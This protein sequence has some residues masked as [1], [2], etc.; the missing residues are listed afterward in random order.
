MRG[1]AGALPRPQGSRRDVSHARLIAGA[2]VV[3][4]ALLAAAHLLGQAWSGWFAL[5]GRLLDPDGY[6]RLVRVERLVE[7]GRWFDGTIPRSN[8][9][10]GETLHWTRPLDALLIAGAAPL[11]PLLGWRDALFAWGVWLS[12]VL[13]AVSLLALLWAARPLLDARGLLALAALYPMQLFLA[14]QFSLGRPDH[15]GLLLLLFIAQLGFAA[16]GRAIAALPAALAVWVSVEALPAG[17]LP[18]AFAGAL[19]LRS[20]EGARFG[21]AYAALLAA[22]LAAA[23]LAERGWAALAP[24]YDSLSIVHVTLAGLVALGALAAAR[25]DR[26]R[27][28][29]AAAA[30]ASVLGGM[31]LAWPRFFAGPLAE[32]DPRIIAAWFA[33]VAEVEPLTDPP[34][35]LAHL[36][37]PALALAVTPWRDRRWAALGVALA[38]YVA[39]ALWQQRWASYAQTLAVAPC[40]ALLARLLVRAPA[41][42]LAAAG[43]GLSVA[44]LFAAAALPAEPRVRAEDCPLSEMADW[45]AAA[46]PE[47]RVVMSYI[48]YGPELLWRTPHAVVSSPYHRNGSGIGD[49]LDFFGAS[50]EAAARAIAERR[51]VGLVLACPA[52]PET[53][54]YRRGGRSL[55]DD[56]EQGRAPAWLEPLEIPP[57]LQAFRL[58]RVRGAR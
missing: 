22:A 4:L 21:A 28:L 46:Q 7:T 14:Q 45:L 57:A 48:F 31:T 18:V 3:G 36:G 32:V 55:M 50:D 5:E 53:G 25:T 9:P 23:L 40:A 33:S 13:H 24:A 20:G 2:A 34:L 12:P 41:P 27:P 56:L 11:A 47:P 58:Y 16:R 1:A 43:V 42:F 52:E 38:L 37:L 29:V 8:A 39:M 30:A 10:Y 44:P 15:H 17:L 54:K 49:A 35:A 19:W 51:G 26:R 6:M